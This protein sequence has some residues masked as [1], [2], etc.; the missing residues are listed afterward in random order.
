MKARGGGGRKDVG[1][2]MGRMRWKRKRERERERENKREIDEK[3]TK[4]EK[5]AIFTAQDRSL[6]PCS[7][8]VCSPD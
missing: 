3:E 6:L 2:K 1:R 8:F 5:Y 4:R 7:P